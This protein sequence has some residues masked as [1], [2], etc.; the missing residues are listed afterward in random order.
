MS[1]LTGPLTARSVVDVL[2]SAWP[3]STLRIAQ[4][5]VTPAP[6]NLALLTIAKIPFDSANW[7]TQTFMRLSRS[8]AGVPEEAPRTASKNDFWED[9]VG[10][11]GIREERK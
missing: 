6:D 2:G 5:S 3:Q 7:S 8:K 1:S 11:K 10:E 9:I 4:P